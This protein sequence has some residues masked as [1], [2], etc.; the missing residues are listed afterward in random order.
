[1]KKLS[2]S[3]CL[4]LLMFNCNFLDKKGI[5]NSIND[6][7]E[8]SEGKQ[9]YTDFCIQCH[10]ANGEGV[11]MLFPPLA[12]SDFLKNNRNK[13]IRAIKYGIEGEIKVNGET[14]NTAMIAQSL[15]NM[16]IANVMN[17]ITNSWGNKNKSLITEAEVSKIER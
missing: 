17:Y 13:S 14:Y 9:I 10:M 15:S 6:S 8:F 11:P 12:T 3:L 5:E 2:F 7:W 1:M 4:V 16:E